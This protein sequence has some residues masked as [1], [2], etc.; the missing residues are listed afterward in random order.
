MINSGILLSEDNRQEI[1]MM[2]NIPFAFSK[3]KKP[4]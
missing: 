3:H 4:F 1:P 2:I